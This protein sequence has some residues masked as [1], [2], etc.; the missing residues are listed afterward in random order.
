[1]PIAVTGRLT[2]DAAHEIAAHAAS[3]LGWSDDERERQ[4]DNLRTVARERHGIDLDTIAA[5]APAPL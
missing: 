3:V 4:L 1:L 2:R 5:A